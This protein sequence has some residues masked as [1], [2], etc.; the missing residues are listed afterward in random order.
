[1]Y[2]SIPETFSTAPCS[3]GGDDGDNDIIHIMQCFSTDPHQ[4]I[5]IVKTEVMTKNHPNPQNAAQEHQ[6]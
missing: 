2:E 4:W 6:Q 1:M 3:G 5:L